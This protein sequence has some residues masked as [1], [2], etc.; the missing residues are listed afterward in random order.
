M[1]IDGD[2]I[3][4]LSASPHFDRFNIDQKVKVCDATKLNKTPE[5]IGTAAG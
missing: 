2:E 1:F 4:S 3:D 5:I